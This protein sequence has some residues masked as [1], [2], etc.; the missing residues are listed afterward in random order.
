MDDGQYK[1]LV[2]RRDEAAQALLNVLQARLDYPIELRFKLR[3]LKALF[4]LSER[5]LRYPE[6]LLLQ[7]ITLPPHAVAGGSFG[8][9]FKGRMAGCDIAVKVLKVYTTSNMDKLLKGFTREAVIW[10]QLSHPNVLSFYGVFRLGAS[11]GQK[12]CLVSPWMQ[13]GNLSDFLADIAPEIDCVPLALDVAKGLEYLHSQNVMHAD[14][15]CGNVLVSNVRRACLADFGL[16]V[17]QDTNSVLITAS[18]TR[19]AGGTLAW[20]AP[21]L[22]LDDT[23]RPDEACDVYSFSMVCYEIFS[24]CIPFKGK[25]G[26][27]VIIAMSQGRRPERPVDSRSY[28]RGLTDRI[29]D[30]IATCWHQTPGERFTAGQAVRRL[31]TLP[32][33]PP[34]NRPV[35]DFS[36]PPPSRAMYRQAHHPFSILEML[37]EQER[38]GTPCVPGSISQIFGLADLWNSNG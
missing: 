7:D 10:R 16:S 19:A 38:T 18:S 20:T 4:K 23:K 22:L 2:A 13:N 3:H 8:D 21:E 31:S 32:D 30:I 28:R 17:A 11:S 36:M 25:S 15:K 9:V 35:D 34:D 5:S 37:S 1:S 24:G 27:Q 12:L 29:W 14:L 33:R 26:P 6:C